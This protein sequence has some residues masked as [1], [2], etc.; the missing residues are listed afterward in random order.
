[1]KP[2][3]STGT[4]DGGFGAA[5]LLCNHGFKSLTAEDRLKMIASECEAAVSVLR[6][7]SYTPSPTPPNDKL[8]DAG[9][10]TP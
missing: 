9:P 2:D 5:P 7:V 8:T 3:N 4:E 6:L 10:K 1:M